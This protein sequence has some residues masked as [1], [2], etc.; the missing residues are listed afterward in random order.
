MVFHGL[1]LHMLPVFL[2]FPALLGVKEMA[3]PVGVEIQKLSAGLQDPLPFL[4]CLVRILQ[5]PGQISGYRHVELIVRQ[6]QLLGVHA[7]PTDPVR[8]TAC[9]FLR[10]TEHLLRVIH[11]CH[12]VAR[13]R[14]NDGEKAR[15]GAD[16]QHSDILRIPVRELH[17]QC[18]KPPVLLLCRQL[19][20]IYL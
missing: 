9:I 2:I 15:A 1:L 16:I 11:G 18:L 10:F 14:Q 17:F 3:V 19:L 5:I 6:F 20:L 4:V 7:H 8:I 12:L 13:L